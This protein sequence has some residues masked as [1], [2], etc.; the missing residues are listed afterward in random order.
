MACSMSLGRESKEVSWFGSL[1]GSID[2]GQDWLRSFIP[3]VSTMERKKLKQNI[4][5]LRFF[6]FEGQVAIEV[7]TSQA[8]HSNILG[9][10]IWAF[11]ELL[12]KV[13]L[14]IHIN[15]ITCRREPQP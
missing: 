14:Y 2:S 3:L 9:F 8:A 12:C 1:S 6:I 5:I 4:E 13:A 15:A 10:K 11:S 7:M